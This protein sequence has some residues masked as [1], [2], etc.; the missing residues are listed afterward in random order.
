MLSRWVEIILI[1]VLILANGFFV[2]AEIALISLRRSKVRQLIKQGDKNAKLIKKLQD[3]PYRFLATIQIGITL[4]GTLTSVVGGAKLVNLIEPLIKRIPLSI[5]QTGSEPIA[6]G[7][8][9][10]LIAYL[11]LIFGEL[12]PKY[13]ALSY[14]QRIAT[15]VAKPIYLLSRLSFLIVKLL[16][17]SSCLV[18]H[19]LIGKTPTESSFI[20]EEEIKYIIS[21]GREKGIFESTEEKLIYRVFEFTDTYVYTAMTPRT[22]IVALDINAPQDKVIQTI[23]EK[24]YSRIPVYKDNLNNIVGVIYVKDI[25]NVLQNKD[26]IILNDIIREPYFVPDSKKI[27]QLLREF[28]AKKTHMAIVS[29]EFGGTV[30]LIT[31]EDILEE[32]VGEIRDEYDQEVEQIQM[33]SDGSAIVSARTN[34]E[35]FNKKFKSKLP[36]EEF[37]TIGDYLTHYLGKIP[38]LDEEIEIGNLRFIIFEKSAHHLSKIKVIKLPKK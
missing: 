13:L 37:D 17:A 5:T 3:E 38:A 15:K 9:V 23:L 34:L 30:G 12:V 29:D 16:S 14:S 24:G 26:L 25:I 27:S 35:D 21:E 36:P 2:A 4:I 8:V 1:L 32:I 33:L 7:L 20:G 28:Q 11:S 18:T 22:E 31:L 19:M 6:I 10:V